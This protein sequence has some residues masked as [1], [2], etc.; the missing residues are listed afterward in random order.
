[1]A[2]KETLAK[3]EE[4]LKQRRKALVSALNGDDSMLIQMN[5]QSGGDVVDFAS[6][7]AWGELST[8]LAEVA[9]REL[10]SVDHA[11]KLMAAGK[12][13]KCEVCNSSIALAR[14]QA[15]PYASCCIDCQRENERNGNPQKRKSSWGTVIDSPVDDFRL[16]DLDTNF[17]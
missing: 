13:G 7:S 4:I 6:D 12:Y 14:L 1:M 9:S 11:L 10:V 3:M 2:R 16:S 15:L 17:S 8:Q 5:Q